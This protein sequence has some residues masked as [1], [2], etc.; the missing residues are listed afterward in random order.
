MRSALKEWCTDCYTGDKLVFRCSPA[1]Q[2]FQSPLLSTT[3]LGAF[4]DSLFPVSLQTLRHLPVTTPTQIPSYPTF[5]VPMQTTLPL[6]PRHTV[7]LYH[8]RHIPP[9]PLQRPRRHISNWFSFEHMFSLFKVVPIA[10]YVSM[11]LVEIIDMLCDERTTQTW[12]YQEPKIRLLLH[13]SCLR[14]D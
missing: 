13:R 2:L 5:T 8:E 11:L 12:G 1:T 4:P 9:H 6:Q 14:R 10:S 7:L 3:R